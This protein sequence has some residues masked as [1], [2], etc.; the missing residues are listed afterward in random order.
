MSEDKEG[1]YGGQIFSDPCLRLD[2]I[3]A[4]QCK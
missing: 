2:G 1:Y 3:S 4:G